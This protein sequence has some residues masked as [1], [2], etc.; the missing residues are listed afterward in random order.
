MSKALKTRETWDEQ[1]PAHM[2]NG[3]DGL[4]SETGTEKMGG[5][6]EKETEIKVKWQEKKVIFLRAVYAFKIF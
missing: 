6:S 1:L 2:D 3:K 5:G 4:V